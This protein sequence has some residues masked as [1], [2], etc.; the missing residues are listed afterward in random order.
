MFVCPI[1]SCTVRM[2]T[3]PLEHVGSE[4]RSE[5]V[6]VGPDARTPLQFPH[7]VLNPMLACHDESVPLS[8]RELAQL[9][10]CCSTDRSEW[11]RSMD[12]E[13]AWATLGVPQDDVRLFD[14]FEGD[15]ASLLETGSCRIEKVDNRSASTMHVQRL[16]TDGRQLFD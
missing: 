6:G 2:S 7:P 16:F 12:L 11:N 4:R 3:P 13:D 15:A 14:V 5:L 10:D 8:G 1:S 9:D